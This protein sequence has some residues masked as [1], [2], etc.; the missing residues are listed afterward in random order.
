MPA[1]SI[2]TFPS[3]ASFS[4]SLAHYLLSQFEQ[5]PEGIAAVRLFLPSRRSSMALRDAMLSLSPTSA[6]LLPQLIPLGD[7]D[8]EELLVQHWVEKEII[9]A[10]LDLPPPI[11]AAERQLLLMQLIQQRSPAG[12]YIPTTTATRLAM[13]LAELMDDCSRYGVAFNTIHTLVPE[14]YAEHWQHTLN[15]LELVFNDWPKM[16]AKRGLSDPIA[17]R[18]QLLYLLSQAWEKVPPSFPVIAAGSTGSM[19]ATAAL[20]KTISNLERG[21]VIL[22]GLDTSLPASCW[23][24]ITETHPQFVLK[25]LLH[26]LDIT[27]EHVTMLAPAEPQTC[28]V[29]RSLTLQQAL[30]PAEN[31]SMWAAEANQPAQNIQHMHL[32]ECATIHE[33]ALVIAT[34]LREAL[35]IPDKTAALI[36]PDRILARQVSAQL[37]RFGI[38]IDDSAGMPLWD[39]A[40]AIFMRLILQCITENFSGHSLLSLLKHPLCSLNITPAECRQL[41]RDI[42]ILLFRQLQ[43]SSGLQTVIQRLQQAENASAEMLTA[44]RFLEH[45]FQPLISLSTGGNLQDMVAAHL[46]VTDA[47]SNTQTIWSSPAGEQLS[48]QMAE[49]TMAAATY[50]TIAMHDYTA[51]FA[52]LLQHATF[53]PSYGTTPRLHIL[54]PVE[55]RMQVLDRAILG[56]LNE[57]CWPAD[58]EISPWL[59][60]SMQHMLGLPIAER[61][62]GQSAHDFMMLSHT[63]EVFYTRASKVGGTPTIASRWLQRLQAYLTCQKQALS[64]HH[65][66]LDWVKALMAQQ[67]ENITPLAPPT[68]AP[69]ADARPD[70]IS[71][72]DIETLLSDPYA[73][74]AKHT[75]QLRELDTI[76]RQPDMKDYGSFIHK[77]LELYTDHPKHADI[78]R[79]LA[80]GQEALAPYYHFT[81]ARHYWWPRFEHLAMWVVEQ[82]KQKKQI[83]RIE[84]E[85]QCRWSCIV[86]SDHYPAI[87]LHT[88][89][90]RIEYSTEG[91]LTLIDFKTGA[92]PPESQV[93]EGISWQLPLEALILSHENETT[94]LPKSAIASLQYWKLAGKEETNIITSIPTKKPM[95]IMLEDIEA[96]LFALLAAYADAKQPYLVTPLEAYAPKFPRYAHLEREDEWR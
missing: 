92:P 80:C 13:S 7:V 81:I 1:S 62:T 28:T 86:D 2:Y 76:E 40:P 50:G 52:S 33:E 88:R 36:T 4:T 12:T 70:S 8:E 17:H 48:K 51:V 95:E 10:V 44:M 23:L 42:E 87:Q 75:L 18:S 11:S 59:N 30:L 53:R 34:L 96:K 79:L 32:L 29:T 69:S 41:A 24:N 46:Q 89:I 66:V 71:V 60:R 90:D 6:V 39:T 15:F 25:Q 31:T 64:T 93:I 61:R 54:S 94:P 47:L 38:H 14:E 74:Y 82:E 27:R 56:G 20:L 37:Q 19:P 26:K 68:P 16:L 85:K 35:E 58:P 84:A 83:S 45:A 65:P 57:G 91:K 55:A 21:M 77:A 43:Q 9:Q 5:T 63:S 67:V 73:V 49:I 72:T 3:N 22:P 78:K